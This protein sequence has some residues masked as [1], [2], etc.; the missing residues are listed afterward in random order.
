MRK[1][2]LCWENRNGNFCK[3]APRVCAPSLNGNGGFL[4]KKKEKKN[5]LFSDV[6]NLGLK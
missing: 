5:L 2:K 6:L 3:P 4:Q 1:E